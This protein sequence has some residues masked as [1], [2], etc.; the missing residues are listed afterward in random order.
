MIKICGRIPF[1]YEAMRGRIEVVKELI[2]V[3]SDSTQVILDGET[4]L[5]L[6]VKYNQLEALQLLVESLS[7]EWEFLNFIDHD[8]SNTILHCF[9]FFWRKILHL[10]MML[11]QIEVSFIL[12]IAFIYKKFMFYML[13]L[14]IN[15]FT[16]LCRWLWYWII[17]T[18]LVKWTCF[19]QGCKQAKSNRVLNIQAFSFIIFFSNMSRARAY[20][21]T[22]FYVQA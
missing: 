17:Y 10:A 21:Q 22:R 18:W 8:G 19:T 15:D 3:W 12:I 5:H 13:K 2:I 6:C 20:Y 9:F 1:H 16:I 7:D 14:D 11:K 4:I